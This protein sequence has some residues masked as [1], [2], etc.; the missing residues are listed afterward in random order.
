MP[1]SSVKILKQTLLRISIFLL[2]VLSVSDFSSFIIRLVQHF[3]LNAYSSM[4]EKVPFACLSRYIDTLIVCLIH[5]DIQNGWIVSRWIVFNFQ[6]STKSNKMFL[7]T[8]FTHT[9]ERT[10]FIYLGNNEYPYKNQY[11]LLLNPRSDMCTFL[12]S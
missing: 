7:R 1:K 10:H 5:H 2:L 3:W 8:L 4:H 12:N 11:F 9:F 6:L